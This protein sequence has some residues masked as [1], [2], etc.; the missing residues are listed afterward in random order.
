MATD[1]PSFAEAMAAF[2]PPGPDPI[3]TM[4]Y[5]RIDPMK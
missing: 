1:L 5:S 4:S 2:C 3:T